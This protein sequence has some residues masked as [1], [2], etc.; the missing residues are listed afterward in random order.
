LFG[1]QKLGEKNMFLFEIILFF[2]VLFSWKKRTKSSRLHFTLSFLRS[3]FF[4]L[5]NYYQMGDLLGPPA[6]LPIWFN[7]ICYA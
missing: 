6:E 5:T 3:E 4:K 7:A 2:I 1:H